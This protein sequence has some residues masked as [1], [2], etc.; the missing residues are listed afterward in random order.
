M[1]APTGLAQPSATRA[2][3]NPPQRT[4]TED[5]SFTLVTCNKRG[6]KTN[7]TP[8]SYA[9]AAEAAASTKQP[10]LTRQP[11]RVSTITEVMVIWAGGFLDADIE[12]RVRACAAD[13]IVREVTLKMAK[14]V[15]KPVPL[16]AGR[17]SIH[18]CSKGNFVYS[19]DGNVPF[20]LIETYEHILLAPFRGSGKLSPS[21]GWT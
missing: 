14:A 6:K 17:W 9:G 1:W 7:P 4:D 19:F 3:L 8:M 21:M 11:T 12:Q 18:P 20:D 13:A 10:P 16:K 2:P 15:A 5:D